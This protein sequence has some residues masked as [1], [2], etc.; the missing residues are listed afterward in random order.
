M[1]FKKIYFSIVFIFTYTILSAQNKQSI[2]SDW[3][4]ERCFEYVK[5]N[6]I[7]IKRSVLKAEAA[8]LIYDQ[9]VLNLYPTISFGT[10]LGDQFGRSLNPS[11]YT[12]TQQQLLTQNY[13][14]NGSVLLYGFNKMQNLKESQKLNYD[15]AKLE[16]EKNI[17]NAH[18]QVLQNYLQVLLAKE[19]KKITELNILQTKLQ[20]EITQKQVSAGTNSEVN[21]IQLKTKLTIDSL[22]LISDNENYENH[23][24]SLKNILNFK[25]FGKFTI[26]DIDL[27]TVSKEHLLNY[28][29][30]YIF[31]E[32]LKTQNILKSNSLKSSYLKLNVKVA[33]ANLL[34]TITLNYGLG[35][36]FSNS[37]Q[38]VKFKDWFQYYGVKLQNN[39]NQQ[40]NIALNIPLF[41]N[42]KSMQNYQSSKLS[43][44]EAELGNEE[45]RNE[46]RKQVN[47]LVNSARASLERVNVASRINENLKEIYEIYLSGYKIGGI[48]YSDLS[49]N[50]NALVK[51]E[52]DLIYNKYDFYL[53][54]KLLDLYL[55]GLYMF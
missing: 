7:I 33:R 42:G 10:Y 30:E 27:E 34:P 39:F 26:K 15:A 37:I 35:S 43:L 16:I 13:Q 12:F 18:F 5:A 41:N 29:S 9:A 23:L 25:D 32:A 49:T 1:M 28:P 47:S 14:M 2:Q 51:S 36:V 8:N 50:Q 24:V 20:L 3:D 53:K 31:N 45:E 22:N 46:L 4:L 40:V 6:N 11:T 17:M 54:L 44:R 55:N 19:K 48:N 52:L 38:G 21:L